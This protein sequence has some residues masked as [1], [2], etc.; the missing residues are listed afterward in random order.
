MKLP[1]RRCPSHVTHDAP[2]LESTFNNNDV[3]FHILAATALAEQSSPSRDHTWEIVTTHHLDD[4]WCRLSV[5]CNAAAVCKGFLVSSLS[6]LQWVHSSRMA[7]PRAMP[8]PVFTADQRLWL[9]LVREHSAS[10]QHSAASALQSGSDIFA[11][12][13]LRVVPDDRHGEALRL[14]SDEEPAVT[15]LS[16]PGGYI[17]FELMWGEVYKYF[18][19][20]WYANWTFDAAVTVMNNSLVPLGCYMFPM[21]IALKFM[22]FTCTAALRHL[23]PLRAVRSHGPAIRRYKEAGPNIL[24]RFALFQNIYESHWRV[25]VILL[26]QRPVLIKLMDSLAMPSTSRIVEFRT[27]DVST[28]RLYKNVV[29]F[30][31]REASSRSSTHTPIVQQGLTIAECVFISVGAGLLPHS[32]APPLHY[33]YP[34]PTY[35]VTRRRG[36]STSG[37]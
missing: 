29:D 10:I 12:D 4:F 19:P 3:L 25:H 2:L 16:L 33:S 35:C 36:T 6:V 23:D 5:L 22:E 8:M 31:N 28:R 21:S 17:N 34:P 14:Q 30:L 9:D 18:A 24:S 26:D 32:S 20:T 27:Y 7:E 13:T 11:I 1:P 15:N 37:W